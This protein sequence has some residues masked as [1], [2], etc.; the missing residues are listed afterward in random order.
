MIIVEQVIKKIGAISHQPSFAIYLGAQ[1]YM[2]H[3]IKTNGNHLIFQ[4]ISFPY[5]STLT[6]KEVFRSK[7]KQL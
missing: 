3:T 2:S 4:V 5:R 7:S 6:T 1:C